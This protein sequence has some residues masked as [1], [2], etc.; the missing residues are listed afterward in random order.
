M[1]STLNSCHVESR[2]S[3]SAEGDV[4]SICR[5][6]AIRGGILCEVDLKSAIGRRWLGRCS[7]G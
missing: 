2:C 3:A 1:T 5:V 4:G 7:G 6:R